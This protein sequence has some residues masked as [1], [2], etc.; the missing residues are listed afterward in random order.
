MKRLH[1]EALRRGIKLGP[2]SASE[3]DIVLEVQPE[4]KSITEAKLRA[5]LKAKQKNDSGP[6]VPEDLAPAERI[7]PI[8]DG[9][10]DNVGQQGQT[11]KGTNVGAGETSGKKKRKGKKKRGQHQKQL[12][13]QS[14]MINSSIREKLAAIVARKERMREIRAQMAKPVVKPTSNMDE[15]LHNALQ[16]LRKSMG[17]AYQLLRKAVRSSFLEKVA[18]KTKSA[19]DVNTHSGVIQDDVSVGYLSVEHNERLKNIEQALKEQ[20][21]LLKTIALQYVMGPYIKVD[22]SI[23]L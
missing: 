7:P 6:P 10:H 17:V 23:T 21:Q 13:E 16:Q 1:R 11:A 9:K 15:T 19:I 22:G 14:N 20:Q 18:L 3:P 8:L 2:G 4:P 12:E 5:K